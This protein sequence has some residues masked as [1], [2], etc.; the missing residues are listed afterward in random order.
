MKG[1]FMLI[2]SIV[3]GLILMSTAST[4]SEIQS[5]STSVDG[6]AHDINQIKSEVQRA[7]LDNPRERD[8]LKEMINQHS[9]YNTEIKYWD[10][11]NCLNLTLRN[12]KHRLKMSC[13]G[14]SSIIGSEI[15]MLFEAVSKDDFD[16]K[17]EFIS[18][19]A[20][21]SANSGNLG[22]GYRNGDSG[23]DLVGYWRLDR[24][25]GR[26]LDYSG[27]NNN[28]SN[29]GANRAVPGVFSTASASFPED[30][31]VI[32]VPH[33]S[34][35]GGMDELT[36]SV[37]IKE[38]EDPGANYAHFISKSAE[39]VG[40]GDSDY[41]LIQQNDREIAFRV[42]TNGNYDDDAAVGDTPTKGEWIHVVGTWNGSEIRLY[43]DGILVD[44]E[45]ATGSLNNAGDPLGI[46]RHAE[47]TN[48]RYFDGSLD[49]IRIYKRALASSEIKKLYFKG[50]SGEFRGNYTSENNNIDSDF[51][52][53]KV[54][55][56]SNIIS[57]TNSTLEVDHSEGG[58]TIVDLDSGE[59]NKNYS[60][61]FSEKGGEIDIIAKMNSTNEEDSPII[62]EIKIWG[63]N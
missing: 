4:V 43:Q 18:T 35:L 44:K 23:D 33:T 36:I 60:L 30:G 34:S 31:D 52:I 26:V 13:L 63:R 24:D 46:G 16:S 3:I 45:T 25:N 38:D 9:D 15:K 5:R 54:Q 19:S 10:N 17:G 51:N 27:E 21:I 50:N 37:W 32:E 62:R 55:V 11:Q 39:S 58:K 6:T 12:N 42:N 8:N 56:D 59:N 20:G 22:L 48:N 61:P 47:N 7:D 2:S 41:A 53:S 28:G 29:K 57:D 40:S 49:E 14:N 1:Q